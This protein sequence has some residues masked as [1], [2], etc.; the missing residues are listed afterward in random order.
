MILGIG[1]DLVQI[2]RIQKVIDRWDHRFLN[3]VYTPAEIALCERRKRPASAFA[4]RFAA[5]EALSKALGTGF[6]RGLAW[7]DI[8]VTHDRRG[9]PLLALRGKAEHIASEQNVL[10]SHVSLSDDGEYA[11]AVVVLED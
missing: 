3:R 5:K 8:E 1:V 11:V 9:K 4:M 2:S 10:R 7:K 6:R